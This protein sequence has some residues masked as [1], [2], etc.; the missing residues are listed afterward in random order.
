MRVATE[1]RT[2]SADTYK[3]FCTTYPDIHLSFKEW[4]KIIY[5]YNYVV[6]DYILESGD[7]A[8][9]PF[10]IGLFAI[11][12]KKVKKHKIDRWGREWINLPIDWQKTRELGYHVYNFNNHSDGYRYKWKWFVK[13][14]RFQ[15][16]SIWNFKPYRDSSRK[17]AQYL[18]REGSKYSE[19]YKEW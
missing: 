15:M 10:G 11:S 6:R 3:R 14:A 17:L 9:I 19:I 12:K 4:K 8:K 16:S 1:Y 13:S 7:M 2:A 18:K 5:T